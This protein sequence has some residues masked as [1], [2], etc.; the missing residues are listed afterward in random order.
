MD[1]SNLTRAIVAENGVPLS[2][3]KDHICREAVAVAAI[4]HA[5]KLITMIAV[6]VLVPG[7]LA[8]VL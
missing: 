4:A 1:A 5:V 7:R 3:A 2:R 6:I 8:V